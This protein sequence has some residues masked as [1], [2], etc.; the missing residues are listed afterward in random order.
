MAT[1]VTS[2]TSIRNRRELR[3][4]FLKQAACRKCRR[5]M[6]APGTLPGSDTDTIGNPLRLRNNDLTPEA[7]VRH[8]TDLART[9][10]RNRPS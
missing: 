6:I 2:T 3:R 9:N 10:D 5:F 8:F 1:P 4:Q 7:N